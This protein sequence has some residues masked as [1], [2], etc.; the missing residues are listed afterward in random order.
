MNELSIERSR[1]GSARSRCS[2]TKAERSILWGL[3]VIVVVSLQRAW[4]FS[5]GSRGDRLLHPHD[6]LSAT[7]SY[8]TCLDF[9]QPPP[10][11]PTV[12]TNSALE[13]YVSNPMDREQGES[14]HR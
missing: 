3:T 2:A 10:P 5:E 11:H 1:S 14:A 13:Q 7:R 9:S 4:R 8:T 12:C 6:T